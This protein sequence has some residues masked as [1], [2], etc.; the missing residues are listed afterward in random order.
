MDDT[1]EPL[2]PL[3]IKAELPLATILRKEESVAIWKLIV[4]LSKSGSEYVATKVGVGFVVL[5]PFVGETKTGTFGG[6]FGAVIV[7]VHA[8]LQEDIAPFE[9]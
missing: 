3:V 7:I 6:L 5:E 8:P 9:S 2:E 4:P 1:H